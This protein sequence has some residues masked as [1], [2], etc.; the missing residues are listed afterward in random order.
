[1]DIFRLSFFRLSL[2]LSLSWRR[3]R[4]QRSHV[5]TLTNGSQNNKHRTGNGSIYRSTDGRSLSCRRAKSLRDVIWA[6]LREA[7]LRE[8][9]GGHTNV[10]RGNCKYQICFCSL[11]E[12]NRCISTWYYI[13]IRVTQKEE[14]RKR[15]ARRS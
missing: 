15:R 2:S 3:L 8:G 6:A 10:Q 11:C 5:R 9:I 13:C 4:Q 1:M 14:I 7:D 12:E